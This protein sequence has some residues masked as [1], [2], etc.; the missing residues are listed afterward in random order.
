MSFSVQAIQEELAAHPLHS[1][2]PIELAI[3]VIDD[4][5]RLGGL[6]PLGASAWSDFFHARAPLLKEQ[7]SMLGWALRRSSLGSGTPPA[8]RDLVAQGTRV[9]PKKSLDSFFKAIEPLTAEMIRANAFRQEEFV[10]RWIATWRGRVDGESIPASTARLNHLDYKK[11][12]REY[13]DT[14]ARRKREAKARKQAIAAAK[15]KK[16][17]ARGWRE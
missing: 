11:A 15:Q 3:S 9:T 13:A 1:P 6:A 2:I 14:E 8:I 4:A 5:L 17:A 16:T 12:L 7:V 10:R